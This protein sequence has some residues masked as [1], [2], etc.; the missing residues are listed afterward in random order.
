MRTRA[1]R[2]LA[3]RKSRETLRFYRVLLRELRE[4]RGADLRVREVRVTR[5]AGRGRGASTG[6]L[7]VLARACDACGGPWTTSTV[8]ERGLKCETLEAR[9][10]CG[11]C[12]NDY[13]VSFCLPAVR[14][15]RG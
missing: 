13:R 15:R 4:S 1:G 12:G 11:R 8:V 9:I 5:S 2:L 7:L 6:V 3:E 10:A 14:R